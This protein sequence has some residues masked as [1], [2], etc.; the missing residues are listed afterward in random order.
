MLFTLLGGLILGPRRIQL[1]TD[2]CFQVRDNIP[3]I[4]MLQNAGIRRRRGL[5]SFAPLES[6]SP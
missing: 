1:H 5:A 6:P 2:T 4:S 3:G